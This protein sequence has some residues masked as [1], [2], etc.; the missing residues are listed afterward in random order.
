MAVE[1]SSIHKIIIAPGQI[2]NSADSCGAITTYLM[3]FMQVQL[4]A[5]KK[6]SNAKTRWENK[7][8]AKNANFIEVAC[9]QISFSCE[10]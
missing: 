8:S 1:C 2:P 4:I 10:I 3:E 6:L 5:L 7:N 9:M